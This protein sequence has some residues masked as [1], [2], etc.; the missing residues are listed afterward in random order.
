MQITQ[1]LMENANYMEA[2]VITINAPAS[3]M[4][5]TVY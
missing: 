2:Y 3:A 1:T 4:H 5:K